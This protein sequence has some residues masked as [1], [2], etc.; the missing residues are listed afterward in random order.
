[1][2]DDA[3]KIWENY[4][5]SRAALAQ[6]NKVDDRHV[7]YHSNLVDKD[8]TDKVVNSTFHD[9][10]DIDAVL[11]DLNEIKRLKSPTF[12]KNEAFSKEKIL[13]LKL[14]GYKINTHSENRPAF[15]YS[16][17]LFNFQAKD[18]LTNPQNSI[19]SQKGNEILPRSDKVKD[20]EI[21]KDR[22]REGEEKMKRMES[23]R[24]RG[25]IIASTS[26]FIPVP[27]GT[28][29]EH[30]TNQIDVASSLRTKY[31]T[32]NVTSNGNSELENTTKSSA[33]IATA[34]AKEIGIKD[35]DG[36]HDVVR[37][38][39]RD[40]TS[41]TLNNGTHLQNGKVANTNNEKEIEST[42]IQSKVNGIGKV[43]PLKVNGSDQM[44]D[45]AV[46][47]SFKPTIE[48][49]KNGF[50]NKLTKFSKI[51]SESDGIGS[52]SEQISIGAQ[53]II[54]SPDDFWI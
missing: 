11:K 17:K 34:D 14:H 8:K 43:S 51:G 6:Y 20:K 47:N 33:P 18:S 7:V 28:G 38:T 16:N 36:K 24:D 23:L 44:V 2:N 45:V 27:L 32:I 53:R 19:F 21:E 52:D 13:P 12:D 1:M 22:E 54:K 31:Q 40:D 30:I 42:T 46:S 5:L 15:D 48:L 50:A 49:A 25:K 41:V 26:S 3:S 10:V 29:A 37:S 4:S 35:S 39:E 9:D